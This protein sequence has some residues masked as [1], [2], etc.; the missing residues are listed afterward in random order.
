[1]ELATTK[2][3]DK[4]ITLMDDGTIWGFRGRKIFTRLGNKPEVLQR[5]KVYCEDGTVRSLLG[6][7]NVRLERPYSALLLLN[8]FYSG[9]PVLSEPTGTYSLEELKLEIETRMLES[10]DPS[11]KSIIHF[12]VSIEDSFDDLLELVI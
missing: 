10:A 4:G 5:I 9:E 2:S 6:Y 12:H 3:I 8:G 1:M 11:E 7:T